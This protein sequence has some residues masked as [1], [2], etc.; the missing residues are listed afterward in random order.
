[1]S[2]AGYGDLGFKAG[3]SAAER[4]ANM[5]NRKQL[6]DLDAYPSRK[7]VN[8]AIRGGYTGKQVASL[9]SGIAARNAGR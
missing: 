5:M 7:V 9:F 2:N 6:Q 8:A 3:A 1:M 4:L